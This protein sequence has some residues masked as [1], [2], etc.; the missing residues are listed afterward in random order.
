MLFKVAEEHFQTSRPNGRRDFIRHPCRRADQSEIRRQPVLKNV[1][2]MLGDLRVFFTV[3]G[4]FKKLSDLR[5]PSAFYSFESDEAPISSMNNTP[6]CACVTAP[7]LAGEFRPAPSL[8]RPDKSDRGPNRSTGRRFPARRNGP[9]SRQARQ[10]RNVPGTV[11]ACSFR[12]FKDKPCSCRFSHT[13]RAVNNDMLRIRSAKGGFQRF[14]A[15]LLAD[16]VFKSR[17]P[18]LF[19]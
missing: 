17:R 5:A 11:S 18:H 14:N 8:R 4:A 15:V 16:D 19:R 12:F 9:L 2:N 7:A 1:V 13:W 6:P 10:R 3:I